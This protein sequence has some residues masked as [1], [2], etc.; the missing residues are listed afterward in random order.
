[1]RCTQ[2]LYSCTGGR[3]ARKIQGRSPAHMSGPHGNCLFLLFI[4]HLLLLLLLLILVLL[5][6]L[7]PIPCLLRSTKLKVHHIKLSFRT[8]TRINPQVIAICAHFT[9]RFLLFMLLLIRLLLLL[10]LIL[11]MFPLL[12]LGLLLPPRRSPPSPWKTLT[13]LR[14]RESS[15]RTGCSTLGRR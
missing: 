3:L 13:P 2:S 12:F 10:L 15:P 14:L 1:M 4:L 6:L 8:G 7:L 9:A 11:I 5:L